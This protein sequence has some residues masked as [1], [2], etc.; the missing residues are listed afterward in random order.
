MDNEDNM[1]GDFAKKE[2]SGWTYTSPVKSLS[3]VIC[4]PFSNSPQEEK[5]A[6]AKI[7]AH[8]HDNL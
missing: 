1:N 8:Y 7:L 3:Q 5:D 2:S 6:F 4:S